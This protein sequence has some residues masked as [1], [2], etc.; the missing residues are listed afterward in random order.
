MCRDREEQY[1]EERSDVINKLYYL[2][3]LDFPS[4]L[5]LSHFSN[6]QTMQPLESLRS[7]QVGGYCARFCSR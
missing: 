2:R 5:P 3:R 7:S 6:L 4:S 1:E